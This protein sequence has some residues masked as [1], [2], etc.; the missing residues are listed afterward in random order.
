MLT[1]IARQAA[2]TGK[3]DELLTDTE[4]LVHADAQALLPLLAQA[5]SAP[6]RVAAAVYRTSLSPNA[7]AGPDLRRWLLSLNAARWGARQLAAD[8]ARPPD[9]P[10]GLFLLR[11]RWATGSQTSPQLR[12]FLTGHSLVTA[13]AT[14]DLE[15]RPVAVTGHDDG[16]VRLWDLHSQAPLGPP[17]TGHDGTVETMTTAELDGR[18]VA[19]TGSRDETAR[20]W[21][22]R[23]G[24]PV[25]HPL[26]GHSSP[27]TAVA[28]AMVEGRPVAVT[29]SDDGIVRIWDL[30]GNALLGRPLEHPYWDD[31]VEEVD[32]VA[33]TVLDSRPIAVTNSDETLRVWDMPT[34]EQRN[35]PGTDA[36]CTQ[37]VTALA[38]CTLQGRPAAI[39]GCGD[40]TVQVWDLDTGQLSRTLTGHD[41][42]VRAVA[43]TLLE[44]RPV[45]VTGGD[46][47]TVRVWDILFVDG[48][49]RGRFSSRIAGLS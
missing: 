48:L 37:G 31:G 33:T 19:I 29:G 18:P 41:G 13:V 45:A 4:F 5:R 49:Q 15:G 14:A 7:G 22:L 12:G 38:A 2:E 47:C 46:D 36:L 25:G 20:I 30:C 26:A 35:Y 32:W 1:G 39:T 6:A 10:S 16:S 43:T 28:T 44:D 21:D 40:G 24:T 11:V 8:L 42:G 9:P 27:V 3:L 34:G 17:L 23:S